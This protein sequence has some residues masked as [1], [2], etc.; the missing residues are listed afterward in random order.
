MGFNSSQ[1]LLP[2]ELIAGIYIFNANIPVII[3]L[4]FIKQKR[5]KI[6][7]HY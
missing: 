6:K 4:F 3:T 2:F 7:I 5:Q 1:Y